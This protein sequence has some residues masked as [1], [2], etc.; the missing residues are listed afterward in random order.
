[1]NDK[2][3]K[4]FINYLLKNFC[5]LPLN[6]SLPTVL[7][8]LRL[9]PLSRVQ[10]NR[11]QKILCVKEKYR[12]KEIFVNILQLRILRSVKLKESLCLLNEILKNEFVN[13][14]QTDKRIIS[15]INNQTPSNNNQSIKSFYFSTFSLY[16]IIIL[17]KISII[18]ND[19]R[20]TNCAIILAKV[21]NLYEKIVDIV[22]Q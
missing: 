13:N 22:K 15:L 17:L 18:R 8:M 16:K 3:F 2:L 7:N 9:Y 12:Q 19:F 11:I 4:G 10:K 14:S 6:L 1:M 20:F 5:K 21:N